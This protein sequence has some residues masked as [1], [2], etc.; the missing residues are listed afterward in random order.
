MQLDEQ[1]V[2]TWPEPFTG[3]T[4]VEGGLQ[5][6]RVTCNEQDVLE[7]GVDGTESR[8]V[9]SNR[10]QGFVANAGTTIYTEFF[11]H[12]RQG[13]TYYV[14]RTKKKKVWKMCCCSSVLSV[15]AVSA[16]E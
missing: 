9:S 12:R 15:S 2:D 13:E 4:G 14:K 16:A 7:T 8:C 1:S 3:G 6:V 10:Q 11:V 5:E